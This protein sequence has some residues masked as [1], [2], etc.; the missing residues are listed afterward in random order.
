MLWTETNL[1]FLKLFY[2]TFLSMHLTVL[3]PITF[4]TQVRVSM[5]D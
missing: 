1:F 4:T 5:G 2:L 3:V